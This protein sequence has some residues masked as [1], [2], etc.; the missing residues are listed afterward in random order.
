M[1]S[2]L[3]AVLAAFLTLPLA[4]SQSKPAGSGHWEGTVQVPDR[5][6]KVA[7]DLAQNE[8]GEWI[9]TIAVPEQNLRDLPLAKIVVKGTSVAFELPGI[10]GDPA[11]QGDLSPDGKAIKGDLAQGGGSFPMQVK[12]VSEASVKLPAKSTPIGKELEGVWEGVLATPDGQNLRIRVTLANGADGAT[13]TFASL[14]QSGNEMPLT[15][16]AQKDSQLTFELKMAGI[17][18]SGELKGDRL[19]GTFTQGPASLPLTFKRGAKN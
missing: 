8:K 3:S 17:G 9:G 19:V 14:D 11:F 1:R 10:P 12:W 13:G 2:I 6:L 16:I 4:L 18:Y 7:I 15:T 5:D